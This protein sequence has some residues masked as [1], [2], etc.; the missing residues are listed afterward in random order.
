MPVRLLRDWTDSEKVNTLTAQAERHF[1]R[2]IMKV[3]DWGR[4]PA[5]PK[6]LRPLLYPFLLDQIREADLQ[7]LSAECA[8]AGLIRLYSVDGKEFLQVEQF[9]Q[10]TRAM[11]SKY[12]G[13][14]TEGTMTVVCQSDEC[15][16]LIHI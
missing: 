9:K 6:I 13:P 4:L 1:I 11:V 5:N 2:I 3:D 7:R 8:R 16:S 12:P 10:R 15:L 14:V